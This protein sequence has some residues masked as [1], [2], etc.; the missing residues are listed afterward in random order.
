MSNLYFQQPSRAAQK[1]FYLIIFDNFFFCIF[2]CC[3]RF[4]ALSI[5]ANVILE[6]VH[7][8]IITSKSL[9]K[10]L[11]FNDCKSPIDHHINYE[12]CIFKN[13]KLHQR[14]FPPLPTKYCSILPGGKNLNFSLEN[15]SIKKSF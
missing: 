9:E 3:L 15:T 13:L 8:S 12:N 10:R 2:A 5:L 1:K 14:P 7:N 6:P 4:S 11:Y